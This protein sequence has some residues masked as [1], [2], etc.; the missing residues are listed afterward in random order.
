MYASGCMNIRACVRSDSASRNPD[1]A[2]LIFV[3]ASSLNSLENEFSNFWSKISSFLIDSIFPNDVPDSS[4]FSPN[5]STFFSDEN[6][7]FGET[8]F[9]G[10]TQIRKTLSCLREI[11][12]SNFFYSTNFAG[13]N[14]RWISL[15]DFFRGQN[16]SLL[17]NHKKHKFSFCSKHSKINFSLLKILFN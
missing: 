12:Y 1:R 16:F 5:M 17:E 6:V 13:Q 11:F 2:V 10:F 15:V 3:S 8:G 14:F 9:S 4:K 7:I